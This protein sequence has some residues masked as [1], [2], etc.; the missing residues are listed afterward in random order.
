M[1]RHELGALLFGIGVVLIVVLSFVKVQVDAQG[2]Y[3]CE[4]VE[5]DPDVA[6]AECPAHDSNISWFIMIAF[7]LAVSITGAGAYFYLVPGS[8]LSSSARYSNKSISLNV[9]DN[10]HP[11]KLLSFIKNFSGTLCSSLY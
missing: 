4:L 11:S 5:A 1:E 2:S 9:L 6:M 3:L 8:T 10:F 7:G